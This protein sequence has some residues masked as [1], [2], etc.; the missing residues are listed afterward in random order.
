MPDR[1]EHWWT[2]QIEGDDAGEFGPFKTREAATAFAQGFFPFA[3]V[4]KFR[5]R[6]IR[7]YEMSREEFERNPPAGLLINPRDA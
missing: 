1:E 2:V 5:G 3:T 4:Y 7:S 6:L